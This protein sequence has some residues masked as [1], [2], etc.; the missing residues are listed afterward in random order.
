MTEQPLI[1]FHP[2]LPRLSKSEKDVLKLLVEAARLIVPI[3]NEQEN[4]A[5]PG[6]NFYP[7]DTTKEEIQK[8]A[9]KNSQILSPYTIVE[10]K[11][12]ELIAIPYHIKYAEFLNPIAEKLK[13]AGQITDNK[14]FGRYLKLQARALIN[15]IYEEAIIAGLKM[16]QYILNISIGPND[17]LDDQLFSIKTSYQ[18]WVGVIDPEGTKEFNNYKDVTLSAVRRALVPE[19][20]IDNRDHVK[21]R[22]DNVV[23]FSGLIA[24]TKFVGVKLPNNLDILAKHG[25]Q[26]W[27]FN[28][29]SD[30]R[31][32]EQIIPTFNKIFPKAFREEYSY[33]DLRKGYLQAVALHELAHSYLYYKNSVESLQDL[34][35]CIDELAATTLGLRLAGPLLLKDIITNKQLESMIV[36]FLCRSFSHVKTFDSYN[37][38]A[39]GGTIFINFMIQNGALKKSGEIMTPN[40][41]KI[42][43]ALQELFSLLEQILA[44]GIRQ[45]AENF[46]KKYS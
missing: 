9:E 22:V 3:Y 45:D 17:Q 21:A 13:K 4:P 38:F 32:K 40:F 39:L 46:I 14:E 34:F 43:V 12:R 41:M 6:A 19:R 37:Y 44:Q 26:I 24:K 1:E 29:L 2:K 10:R 30:L 11:G 35:L 27:L 25:S 28:Q 18:C 31:I 42:F 5:F 33:K 7:H 8:A 23:L 16:K 36:V 20:R 15:G